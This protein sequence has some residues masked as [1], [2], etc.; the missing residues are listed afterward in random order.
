MSPKN[1]RISEIAI[2]DLDNIW[3][4]TFKNYSVEQANRYYKLIIDE[5]EF[6]AENFMSGKSMDYIKTGYRA[7]RVKSHLIF[8]RKAED[9]K[10]EV[11]RVLHQMMDLENWLT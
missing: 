4:Y 9:N 2:E 5:I 1:Y 6:I 3:I 11:I 8:Y 10:V 7:T